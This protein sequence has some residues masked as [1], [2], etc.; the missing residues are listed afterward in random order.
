MRTLELMTTHRASQP[1]NTTENANVTDTGVFAGSHAQNKTG[2]ALLSSGNSSVRVYYMDEDKQVIEAEDLSQAWLSPAGEPTTVTNVTSRAAKGSPI[3][4]VAYDFEDGAFHR[5]LFFYD[6]N[7]LISTTNATNGGVWGEV[8]NPLTDFASYPGAKGLAACAGTNEGG[9]RGMRVYVA[10]AEGY[11]QEIGFDFGSSSFPIWNAWMAFKDGSDPE[12]GVACNVV[13]DTNRVYFRNKT[14]SLLHQWTWNYAT[15]VDAWHAGPR[16]TNTPV[17]D[18]GSIAVTSDGKNTDYLFF[19]TD[20]DTVVNGLFTGGSMSDFTEG[21]P[22]LSA[23]PVGYQLA[24]VWTDEAT[25]INQN[26]SSPNKM[27][28]STVGRDG[29]ARNG[30]VA[31]T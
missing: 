13:D 7:G 3:A 1:P 10:N 23:A 11:I 26:G 24:A 8:Y 29:E 17:A 21:V 4:A 31:S 9:L 22:S 27:M 16:S 25:M 5:Q 14:T 6:T 20:S 28:F 18:G 19:H 12:A 30:T 15:D 2:L